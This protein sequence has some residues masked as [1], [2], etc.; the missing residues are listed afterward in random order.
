MRRSQDYS[1]VP[2]TPTPSQRGDLLDGLDVKRG[3][4]EKQDN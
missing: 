1:G 3:I 4:S 2:S